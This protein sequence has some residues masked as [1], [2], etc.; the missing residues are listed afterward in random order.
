MYKTLTFA[1][2]LKTFVHGRQKAVA[3][4]QMFAMPAAYV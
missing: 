3:I 4:G 2:K 1:G